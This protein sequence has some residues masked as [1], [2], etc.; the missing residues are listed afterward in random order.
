MMY[1]IVGRTG[2][3][4][5]YLVQLLT[6]SGLKVVKSYATRPKRTENED[7]HIFIQPEEAANY[8]ER[9]AETKIG[10]YEYFATKQQVEES[11]VYVI[12]PAGVEV[13]TENM[14]DT[15]FHIVYVQASE[16]DRKT[17]AV[18]RAEDKIKEEEVFDARNKAEDGQFS[19]FEKKLKSA[20]SE[21]AFPSN[22]IRIDV[23]DNDYE[24]ASA[25]K[26][27]EYLLTRLNF[28]NKMSLVV[29]EAMD[30]G[31]LTKSKDDEK[32]TC[33]KTENG[34]EKAVTCE[35][36]AELLFNEADALGHM[37][38]A[39]INVSPRFS[40]IQ[41]RYFLQATDGTDI[42]TTEYPSMADAKRAMKNA[43]DAFH[44]YDNGEEWEEM[45][46]IAEE[47][48]LLYA[49]GE[50]VYCWNILTV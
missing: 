24:E 49:N 34:E 19:E 38:L 29:M 7:T 35:H 18:S 47:S 27:A 43:Y 30:L 36:M 5:D 4:K 42:D 6:Q 10:Q 2:A 14:P 16:L 8:T 20:D 23:F 32:K 9:V 37:M 41:H 1:L 17:H 39:Y 44:P 13:L 3:G 12:D 22:V 48:A 31:I 40:S 11:N 28:H 33:V 50:N 21:Q 26:F 25:Q 45:S 15:S 46:Y